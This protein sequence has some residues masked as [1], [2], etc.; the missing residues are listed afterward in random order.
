MAGHDDHALNS[1]DRVLRKGSPGTPDGTAACPCTHSGMTSPAFPP[2]AV[3]HVATGAAAQAADTSD[4]VV[5]R[6]SLAG[7]RLCDITGS[8]SSRGRHGRSR[9]LR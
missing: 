3:H 2:S 8:R 6:P 1:A 9:R 5:P 7:T 4:D